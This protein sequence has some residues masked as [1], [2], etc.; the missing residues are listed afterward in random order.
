MKI[1]WIGL[2]QMG[3][4]MAAR[5]AERGFAVTAYVRSPEASER[6]RARGIGVT[7]DLA[8]AV[9]PAD[10]VSVG[11]FDDA[12]FRAVLLGDG[13]AI[14]RMK[15]GAVLA[16]HTT[17]GPA[18]L[19]EAAAAA[20][21]GVAIL[22]ATFSGTSAQLDA[23]G[24]VTLMVGGDVAALD[25]ARPALSSYCDP[26][27]HVGALGA[28]RRL[29][30]LNNML[31][32]AQVSLASETLRLAESLGL[33]AKVAGPVIQQS[34]GA[35]FAM[36]LLCAADDRAVRLKQLATYLD[37]DVD[38]ARSV[39]AELGLNLGE[40]GNAAAQWGKRALRA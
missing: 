23:G 1:G 25:S 7:T 14:G 21:A 5:L 30:L 37:K 16:V 28:A 12:Q 4:A 32:A 18:A 2:G 35:S 26:I 33:D 22:D 38:A 29:K 9:E 40:L 27:V 6:A 3:L 36:N 8:E 17:G 10:L 13:G 39:A 34:S 11:L 31:F 19:E 24:F 15:P 20:P